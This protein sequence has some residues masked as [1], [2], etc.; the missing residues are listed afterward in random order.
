MTANDAVTRSETLAA[1]FPAGVVAFERRGV[2]DV[3]DLRPAE[4]AC[5]AGFAPK[6]AAEFAA[7][8]ACA[9]AALAALG[10][11]GGPLV[12][13]ADRSPDW[14]PGIVGSISHT[15]GFCAAVAAPAAAF[16]GIGIDVELEDRVTPDLWE[17][18]FVSSERE[19]LAALPEAT[20]NR[21]AS[22]AFCAKEAF[23]KC[24]YAI[25]QGWVDFQ[26]AAVDV[27]EATEQSGRFTL[28]AVGTSPTARLTLPLSGRFR[29]EAGLIAAAVAIIGR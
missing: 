13:R 14:P 6:R 22:I 7:G 1:L 26:D 12:A 29:I 15:N 11:D 19:R 24:Q 4:A 5:C 8:R 23:Y 18:V 21:Y 9:H 27:A 17:L 20:R 28:R 16:A 25:T 10:R 2:G 3:A